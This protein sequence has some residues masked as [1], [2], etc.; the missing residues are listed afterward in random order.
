MS[1]SMPLTPGRSLY[2][3]ASAPASICS[4]P[5]ASTT[6]ALPLSTAWRARNSAVDPVE[7]ALLTLTIGMPDSP[8]GYSACCPEVVSPITKPT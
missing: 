1:L 4:K 7:Q 8:S 5:S 6:S 2:G 3:D